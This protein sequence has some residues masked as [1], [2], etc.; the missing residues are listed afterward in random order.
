MKPGHLADR[1][2]RSPHEFTAFPNFSQRA[3]INHGMSKQTNSAGARSFEVL[4]GKV[5]RRQGCR[6]ARFE[7]VTSNNDCFVSSIESREEKGSHA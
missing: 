7:N 1:S 6:V 4:S 3:V 5:Y 2:G